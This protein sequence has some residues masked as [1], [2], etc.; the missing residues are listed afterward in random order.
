MPYKAPKPP[1]STLPQKNAQT[2]ESL[3]LEIANLQTEISSLKQNRGF[4]VVSVFR[5]L[6]VFLLVTISLVSLFSLNLSFWAK[7][8]VVNTDSFIKTASPIINDAAVQQLI[9]SR[10]SD[11]LFENVNVEERLKQNL[12]ENI[13][14]LAPTLASQ[15]Q[16]V[17]KSQI[18]NLLATDQL[19]TVWTKVLRNSH[20]S[21]IYFIENPN[22]DGV[23][24]VN[25]LYS[26]VGQNST[27]NNLSFLFNRQLPD[28][29][30]QIELRQVKWLPEARAY[31]NLVKRA[32][33]LLAVVFSI[34]LIGAVWLSRKKLRTLLISVIL[35]TL[36][37]IGSLWLINVGASQVAI[38]TKP[39]NRAAVSAI[40]DILSSTLTSQTIGFA[41]LL[42]A[43]SVGLL[44]A[45]NFKFI[46]Y[47]KKYIR[48]Y[49]DKASKQI[50]PKFVV[51]GWLQQI[52]TNRSIIIIVASLVW[53]VALALRI[54]P[55]KT[56]VMAAIWLS[57][58]TAVTVEVA[59]SI[60]RTGKK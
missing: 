60:A 33:Q 27:N 20:S 13:Q 16:G 31:L 56:G 50:F 5:S 48:H 25:E 15:I 3:K 57:V 23:I 7:D 11:Q 37:M 4:K 42:G 55:T 44:L 10:L 26:F 1:T 59:A 47:T 6:V 51:P 17:T 53:L 2:I 36:T 45:S 58:A 38:A 46:G 41:W 28:R 40:Y 22:N 32:P 52:E 39:E 34:S 24:S 30:G 35:M 18:S 14:F 8:N 19:S 29:F 49:L 21:L 9:A 54:P 12:P 43:I